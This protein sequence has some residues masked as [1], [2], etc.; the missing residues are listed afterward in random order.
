ML[1][2]YRLKNITIKYKIFMNF[3]KMKCTGWEDAGTLVLRLALGVIFLY[4]GYDKVFVK[5]MDAITGFMSSLGLPLPTLMAYLLSYGELIGG[6]LLILGL[7]T[8][9]VSIIDI[10]IA[11]VA[12]FTVHIT[13]GFAVGNGGYEFIMLILAASIFMLTNG[14]GRYSADAMLEKDSNR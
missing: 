6:I 4:H 3:L 12:L 13:K 10:V 1:I 11:V 9:W 8:Y 5:G 14:A 2:S 7:F